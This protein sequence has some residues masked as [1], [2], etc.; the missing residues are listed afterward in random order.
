[1]VTLNKLAKV[2]SSLNKY[3]VEYII[4]G[5]C[6]IFIHG[7]ERMTQ[8]IDVLINA[9]DKNIEKFKMALGEFLPEACKELTNNDIKEN[10]VIRMVSE[11]LI[12]DVIHRIGDFDYKTIKNDIIIEEIYGVKILVAGLNSMLKLKQGVRE[13]DKKD[14]LFLLGKK[15]YLDEQKNDKSA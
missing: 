6:A 9:N 8:D 11:D 3:A 10:A 5:G 15:K 1:M 7:Y 13:T 2:C 12:I 4:I 14:F